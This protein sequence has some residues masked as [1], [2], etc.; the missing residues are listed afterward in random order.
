MT[1]TRSWRVS[2]L[3]V[4]YE[5]CGSATATF[6]VRGSA[7]TGRAAAVLRRNA[8]GRSRIV[9]DIRLQMK[10]ASIAFLTAFLL[11]RLPG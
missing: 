5:E 1:W 3:V 11:Q 7:V 6:C 9:S 8:R 4:R 2:A 10:I